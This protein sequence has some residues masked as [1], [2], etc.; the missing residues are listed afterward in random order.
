VLEI[1]MI[2]GRIFMRLHIRGYEANKLI[3]LI[4]LIGLSVDRLMS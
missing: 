2:G 4:K 1:S 3:E